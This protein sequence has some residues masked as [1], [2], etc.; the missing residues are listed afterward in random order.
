MLALLLALAGQLGGGPLGG[1]GMPINPLSMTERAAPA[2]APTGQCR[3]YA[4]STAHVWKQSC[5]GGAY[6]AIASLGGGTFTGQVNVLTDADATCDG[7]AFHVELNGSGV[8]DVAWCADGTADVYVDRAGNLTAGG[9]LTVT[10]STTLNGAT[11]IGDN[12]ADTVTH[13]AAAVTYPNDT[14]LTCT[15]DLDVVCNGGTDGFTVD[16]TT[17]VVNCTDNAL[18]V[19]G[20]P[21]GG[22]GTTP[23]AVALG[24]DVWGNVI[25]GSDNGGRGRSNNTAKNF[26]LSHPIFYNTEETVVSMA[27]AGDLGSNILYL[28]NPYSGYFGITTI[29]FY[30][31]AT[32]A[33]GADVERV[34][35]SGAGNLTINATG[36]LRLA[37][38][39]G[40]EYVA[41]QAS[42]TTITYTITEAPAAPTVA[43]SVPT[44]GTDGVTAWVPPGRATIVICGDQV[45]VADATPVY[46]GP[47][48]TLTATASGLT[49]DLA[50]AGDVTEAT[51]DEPAFDALAFQVLSLVCRNTADA[52]AA[53]SYTLRTAAGAT[54]PSVTCSIADNGR[55]CTTNVGTTT[56]IASAATLAVAVASTADLGANG[57]VCTLN[58]AF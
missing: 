43:G 53:V 42:A 46:Y 24:L 22:V 19:G 17:L 58:V 54:T 45:T 55:D 31:S 13:N 18:G 7:A 52:N 34:T 11:V 26:R 20:S 9:A 27:Y 37:D 6:G 39:T 28:G 5:N 4:D 48:R 49:C 50:A 33:N 29:S 41:R 14:T 21:G 36:D 16:G 3:M 30:T 35:I 40:G 56:A 32:W 12:P 38:T 23:A 8:G 1:V 10:G 47:N 44:V 57:F 15:N 2:V 51:V 25:A